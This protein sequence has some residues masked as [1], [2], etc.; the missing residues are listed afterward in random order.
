MEILLSEQTTVGDIVFWTAT[1]IDPENKE[2]TELQPDSTLRRRRAGDV[3]GSC[4]WCG[5]RAG[6]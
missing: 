1:L 4:G 3:C 6:H 2:I 5:L